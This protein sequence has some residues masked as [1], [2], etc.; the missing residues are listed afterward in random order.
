MWHHIGAHFQGA[1][2][3]FTNVPPTVGGTFAKS[4]KRF[5]NWACFRCLKAG[6]GLCGPLLK[7]PRRGALQ[8][9]R[10][11]TRYALV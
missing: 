6:L 9:A 2:S 10:R 7:A 4:Q 5:V 8:A 11:E 3:D 1:E